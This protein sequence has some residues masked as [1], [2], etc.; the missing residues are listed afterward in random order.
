MPGDV[1]RGIGKDL[2][3]RLTEPFGSLIKSIVSNDER[4]I[5]DSPR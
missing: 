3:H 5:T 4:S 2:P 1:Q